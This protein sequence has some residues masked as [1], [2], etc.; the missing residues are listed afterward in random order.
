MNRINKIPIRLLQYIINMTSGID[1]LHMKMT[2][3][4]YRLKLYITK[5]HDICHKCYNRP[6]DLYCHNCDVAYCNTCYD[7]IRCSCGIGYC[8]IC[9]SGSISKCI[10]KCTTYC[11]NCRGNFNPC[12]ICD[13]IVCDNCE[14]YS[15]Y[16]KCDYCQK[17][18]CSDCY[19]SITTCMECDY[20]LCINCQEEVYMD[21]Y[22]CL[23]NL[24]SDCYSICIICD[25]P[26]CKSCWGNHKD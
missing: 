19:S 14:D 18:I 9:E 25:K 23:D 2:C 21:C 15:N 12:S 3:K 10:D 13:K 4:R 20:S 22:N 17:D 11:D 6:S 7:N 16:I 8:P 5:P 24:C 26:F 1:Q